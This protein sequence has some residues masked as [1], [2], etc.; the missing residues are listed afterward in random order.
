[1]QWMTKLE[2][3]VAGWLKNVPHLPESARR[4]ISDNAWWIV[5]IGT[6]ITAFA[7]LFG[8]LGIVGLLASYGTVGASYYVAATFTAWVLVT[9]IVTF[10][11]TTLAL[12]LLAMAINPLKEKQ[13]K[14]WVLLFANW[15]L[16]A[17]AIVINAILSLNPVG[18]ITGILFGAVWLAI[19]GYFLFEIHG[20]FAHVEK[21][22]G[23]KEARA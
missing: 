9:T 8:L 20:Q 1:M 22:K 5:L 16:S 23:I 17:V 6:I 4:W 11:F 18:F 14:G 13:K 10:V 15:L 21:S 12:I 19:S 7:V 3:M 2:H